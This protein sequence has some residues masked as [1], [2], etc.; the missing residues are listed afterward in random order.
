VV[1]QPVG[2]SHELLQP[3]WHRADRLWLRHVLRLCARLLYVLDIRTPIRHI[4][5][6]THGDI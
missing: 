3:I 5:P 1:A 6:L 4:V 2:L